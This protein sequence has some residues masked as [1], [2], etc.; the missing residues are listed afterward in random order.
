MT[1]PPADP[2]RLR[3]AVRERYASVAERTGSCCAGCGDECGC[4]S[5]CCTPA[6]PGTTGS[7]LGYSPDDLA[8]VPPGANLGL[9]CGNPTALL[10]L[11]S[12]EVVLDLGSGGGID[13]FIA[14]RRVGPTGRVI[15][16]D[17]TP[18]MIARARAQAQPSGGGPVE[19]RLGEIEHLPVADGAVD[20]VLSNCVINLVPDV[21]QVYREAYRVLRPGGRLAVADVLA[22][23]PVPPEV[24]ADVGRWASCTA[25]ARFPEEITD[26]LRRAG[27]TEIS[28]EFRA[29]EPAPTSEQR[30]PDLGVV[31]GSIRATKPLSP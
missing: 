16:V 25:G 4:N 11:R 31:S 24:R 15:G 10:S 30:P 3:T 29:P 17:M 26:C 21:G 23:R 12:G 6:D 20:V 7:T 18:E 2:D 13:C 9:G 1:D 22:T 8:L 28:V 14:A 19:F 5:S 27:F